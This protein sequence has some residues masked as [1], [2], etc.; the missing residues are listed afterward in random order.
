ML[1]THTFCIMPILLGHF[2]SFSWESS[3]RVGLMGLGWGGARLQDLPLSDLPFHLL[4]TAIKR[5]VAVVVA[6]CSKYTFVL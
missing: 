2:L 5:C 3:F 4:L 6:S 1:S